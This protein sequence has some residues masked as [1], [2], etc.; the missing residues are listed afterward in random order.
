MKS[1]MRLQNAV[2]NGNLG[3]YLVEIGDPKVYLKGANSPG[4]GVAGRK[5]DIAAGGKR[6]KTSIVL[7]GVLCQFCSGGVAQLDICLDENEIFQT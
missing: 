2:W 4:F 6:G 5:F 7:D 3:L 1:I